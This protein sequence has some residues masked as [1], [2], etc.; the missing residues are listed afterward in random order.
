VLV[1]DDEPSL[2]TTLTRVLS[3]EGFVV[4]VAN[5]GAQGLARARQH[6]PSVVIVDLHM[7]VMD[8]YAFL[9]AF[10]HVPG[11]ADVPIILATG[12]RDIAL[13]RQRIEGKGVVLLM[14]KPFDLDTLL[15]A[16]E[17][18]VRSHRRRDQ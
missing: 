16:V 8:G 5:D 13:A 15:T 4:D 11:C 18:A 7:P 17:G 6:R 12:S 3:S 1:I 2:T 9:D 10:R 14:P